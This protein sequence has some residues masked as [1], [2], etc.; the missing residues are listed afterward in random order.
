MLVAA[1]ANP[2]HI[3]KHPLVDQCSESRFTYV[4]SQRTDMFHGYNWVPAIALVQLQSIY[5][6]SPVFSSS[7]SSTAFITTPLQLLKIKKSTARNELSYE[8][9]H[10]SEEA[11][12]FGEVI[13]R[14]V[15]VTAE[16]AVSKIFPAGK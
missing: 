7:N 2:I 11:E 9:E 16:V 14:R 8:T 15:Q 13:A 10:K 6:G 3:S 12:S 5:L 4:W 1:N